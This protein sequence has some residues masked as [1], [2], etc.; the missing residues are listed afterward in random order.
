MDSKPWYQ[1]RAIWGGIVA[2]ASPAIAFA[3]H[4][5]IGQGDIASAADALA[6]IGSGIGGLI[7]IYG[8]IKATR[9]I[10]PAS[11]AAT[12]PSNS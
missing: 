9:L 2:I 3:A 8:R 7:A 12:N 1:S 5:T 4:V 11:P 6:S 10:A